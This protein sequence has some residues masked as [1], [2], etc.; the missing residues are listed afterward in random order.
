MQGTTLICQVNLETHESTALPW[1]WEAVWPPH[2][3]IIHTKDCWGLLKTSWEMSSK[4][5]GF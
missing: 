1:P 3:L 2:P 5:D 4:M